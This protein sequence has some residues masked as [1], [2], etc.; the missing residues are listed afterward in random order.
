MVPHEARPNT[1]HICN[2]SFSV[3]R[4]HL[5]WRRPVFSRERRPVCGAGLGGSRF[6]NTA[7]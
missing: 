3:E 5:D 4:A 6:E 1:K 2:L 7:P